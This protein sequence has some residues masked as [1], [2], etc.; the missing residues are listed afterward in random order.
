MLAYES[1]VKETALQVARFKSEVRAL[2]E[3]ARDERKLMQQYFANLATQVT[4]FE[5]RQSRGKEQMLCFL[6]LSCFHF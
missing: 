2:D 6:L 5:S 3:C 1:V 4:M